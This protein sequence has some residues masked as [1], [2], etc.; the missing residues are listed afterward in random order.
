MGSVRTLPV[1][2]KTPDSWIFRQY[3]ARCFVSYNCAQGVV[4]T[5]SQLFIS[6][7]ASELQASAAQGCNGSIKGV[8]VDTVVRKWPGLPHPMSEG[9]GSDLSSASNSQ[10]PAEVY[11]EGQQMLFQ[12]LGLC[13]P[14]GKTGWSSQLLV[15]GLAQLRL[16][17]LGSEPTDRRSVGL[18]GVERF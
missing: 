9:L 6:G 15:F 18:G 5:Q 16:L 13:H 12:V 7:N 2:E 3:P 17:D 1:G 11:P 4:G 8:L 14:H 10:L